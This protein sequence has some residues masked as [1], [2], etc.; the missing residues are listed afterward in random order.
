MPDDV[1][2]RFMSDAGVGSDLGLTAV[3]G[4]HTSSHGHHL[5]EIKFNDSVTIVGIRSS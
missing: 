4:Y 2:P 5:S 1:I 3:M